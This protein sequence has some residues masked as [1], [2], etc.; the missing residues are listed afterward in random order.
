ML[1]L[2]P[3]TRNP[4]K[5]DVVRTMLLVTSIERAQELLTIDGLSSATFEEDVYLY[6]ALFISCIRQSQ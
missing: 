1:N 5:V 2:K 3:W 4:P 6:H